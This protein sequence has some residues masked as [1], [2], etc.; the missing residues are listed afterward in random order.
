MTK[1][2]LIS[3]NAMHRSKS[4]LKQAVTASCLLGLLALTS[5]SSLTAQEQ[6]IVSGTAIGASVG[7]ATSAVTGWCIPCGLFLGA[8]VG[9][10]TGYLVDYVI[11][12]DRR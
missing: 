1:V 6:R 2:N 12:N 9:A 3:A 4:F 10:G 11:E 8:G 7:V 5:C